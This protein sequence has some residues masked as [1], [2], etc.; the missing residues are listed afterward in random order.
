MVTD[1]DEL[2]LPYGSKSRQVV[3]R[4]TEKKIARSTGARAH[5][6]SGAGS[7]KWDASTETELLEIKDAN[8]S[9]TIKGAMLDSLYR[10]AVREGKTPV[11][12][13][14]FTDSDI[15]VVCHVQRG[16]L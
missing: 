10:D 15:T 11:Y 5:P 6:M 9:H 3:G 8:R 16:R 14:Y 4:D 2:G 7:I 1:S 13:V 12:V